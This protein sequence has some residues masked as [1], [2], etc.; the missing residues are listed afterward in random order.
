M[1]VA[2]LYHQFTMHTI[3]YTIPSLHKCRA[4]VKVSHIIRKNSQEDDSS[5]SVWMILAVSL[6]GSIAVDLTDMKVSDSLSVITLENNNRSIT[7][8]RKLFR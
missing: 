8:R 6:L 4:M 1:H 2:S 7:I 5:S 3:P